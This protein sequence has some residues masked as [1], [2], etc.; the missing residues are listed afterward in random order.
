MDSGAHGVACDDTFMGLYTSASCHARAFPKTTAVVGG[1]SSGRKWLCKKQGTYN[2]LNWRFKVFS[3]ISTNS[4]STKPNTTSKTLIKASPWTGNDA[5]SFFFLG[6]GGTVRKKLVNK[7][8][9]PEGKRM[10]KLTEKNTPFHRPSCQATEEKRKFS[11]TATSLRRRRQRS[12]TWATAQRTL[13]EER[14]W[15]PKVHQARRDDRFSSRFLSLLWTAA[16]VPTRPTPLL[17][18]SPLPLSL[19]LGSGLM[20]SKMWLCQLYIICYQF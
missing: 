3:T 17:L 15:R 7:I 10:R 4:R 20:H 2:F 12:R 9:R 5:V 14:K 18:H 1:Q 19:S 13:V 8:R 16:I 6:G 11:P